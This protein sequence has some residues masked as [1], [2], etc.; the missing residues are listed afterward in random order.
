MIR[1]EE[2]QYDFL[3]DYETMLE[4]KISELIP[5]RSSAIE[6]EMVVMERASALMHQLYMVRKIMGDNDEW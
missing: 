5:S 6:D 3:N 2:E 1:L 4:R